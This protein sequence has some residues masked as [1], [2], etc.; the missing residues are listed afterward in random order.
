MDHESLQ[1]LIQIVQ[2]PNERATE[3]AHSDNDDEEME[4]DGEDELAPMSDDDDVSVDSD[5]LW[6]LFSK[7]FN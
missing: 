5:D 4:E 3:I 6:H 1:N 7:K 2:T